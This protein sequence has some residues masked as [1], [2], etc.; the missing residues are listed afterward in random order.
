MNE[1]LPR[2]GCLGRLHRRLGAAPGVRSFPSRR[3]LFA[4]DRIWVQPRA[5]L[6]AFRAHATPLAR[7]ASDHLPVRGAIVWAVE[8]ASA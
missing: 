8:A 4:L 7:M 2:L 6:T 1:W 3:P 5:G